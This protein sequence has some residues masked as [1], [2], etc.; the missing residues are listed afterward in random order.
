MLGGASRVLA[1]C[2]GVIMGHRG[3]CAVGGYTDRGGAEPALMALRREG[4]D[5]VVTEAGGSTSRRGDRG[6]TVH[7][8]VL[9]HS[10]DVETAHEV[11][12]RLA[13]GAAE[14]PARRGAGSWPTWARRAA[15]VAALLAV[16]ALTLVILL[17]GS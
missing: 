11:L 17:V 8:W 10:R 3:W 13:G 16:A 2:S 14:R 7:A 6:G 12:D 4:I 5:A 1:T 15:P 9:V